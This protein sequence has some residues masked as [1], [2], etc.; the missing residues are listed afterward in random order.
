M[1]RGVGWLT[2]LL[3]A[4]AAVGCSDSHA[5]DDSA[6][7]VAAATPAVGEAAPLLDT[8]EVRRETL[9][10]YAPAIGTLRARRMT[11]LGTQVSGRVEEVLVEVGDRVK[12]DQVLVRLDPTFFQIDVRELAAA[13]EAARGALAAAAADEMEKEREKARQLD[14][15]AGGSGSTKDRDDA[16]SE[17]DAA[18]GRRAQVAAELAAA[19]QR[20]RAGEERLAETEIRA[21]YDAMVTLRLVDP[22]Q[23][24]QTAPPTELIEIQETGVLYLEFA[25]PQ[26]LRSAVDVG[27]PVEFAVEG[28]RDGGGTVRLEVIYPALDEATRAFRCRAVLDNTAQ[29]LS[30]GLLVE[31][32]ALVEEARDVLVVPRTAVAPAREGWQVLVAT[33]GVPEVRAVQLGMVAEDRAQ[34]LR[35]LAEGDRVLAAATR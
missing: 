19:E 18:V 9:R 4:G 5:R 2:G 21:P 34:V 30:P 25:L 26:E 31:V 33:D 12:R 3:A 10:R 24:A 8:I 14:L 28:V 13:V 16:L 15:F 35:G 17:Y 6:P 32:R 27:T 11:R 7:V 20:L 22:G 23:P 1:A 29:R